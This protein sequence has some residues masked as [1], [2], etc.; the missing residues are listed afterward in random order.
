M[1]GSA[2]MNL[3]SDSSSP[4]RYLIQVKGRLHADRSDCFGNMKISQAKSEKGFAKTAL[5]G[6][7][8]DQ[9]ELFGILNTLYELHLPLLF[10]KRLQE[11]S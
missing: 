3:K 7:I 6:E 4:E 9:A 10:V 2:A 5:E 11:R 1:H 8:R